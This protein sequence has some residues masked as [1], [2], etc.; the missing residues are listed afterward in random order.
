MFKCVYYLHFANRATLV[1]LFLGY[2]SAWNVYLD[3]R[4]Y[5]VVVE[6]CVLHSSLLCLLPLPTHSPS[7]QLVI[8]M[9]Q[10]AD[11]E[12]AWNLP[13]A[14]KNLLNLLLIH[15]FMIFIEAWVFLAH[16]TAQWLPKFLFPLTKCF[17]ILNHVLF[18]GVYT[19]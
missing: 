1:H 4:Y 8:K 17:Y 3:I 14:G 16:V 10:S 5:I 2:K 9:T 12:F 18:I 7:A 6:A 19:Q 15:A 11:Y 13:V